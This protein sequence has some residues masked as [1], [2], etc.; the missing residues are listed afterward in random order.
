MDQR[1]VL[2]HQEYDNDYQHQNF[3]HKKFLEQRIAYVKDQPLPTQNNNSN[4]RNN[5]P[6][7][8]YT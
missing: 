6:K 8:Y 1:T 5:Q 2:N 7:I 3:I 4:I